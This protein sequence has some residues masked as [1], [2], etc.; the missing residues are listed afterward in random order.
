[1]QVR[2]ISV[3]LLIDLSESTNDPL[4]NSKSGVDFSTGDNEDGES[5]E[6]TI[7]D[8]SREAAVLMSEAMN[9]V[10]DP[11]AI[12]GFDSN[13]RHDVE[14]YRFKD[15]DDSYNDDVKSHLAG[16]TGQ[17]S[18]RMGAAIRHSGSILNQYTSSKKILFVLTDGEPADNDVRDPQ[19]LRFDT[20]KA[21]E[22]LATKGVKT[23]CL[24]LDP[25][26]DEYVSRIFG[27]KNYLILDHVSRLPEKLPELY[28]SLTK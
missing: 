1:L 2:D 17:L 21:V 4:P 7:L 16:M 9:K 18:T 22:E 11:F 14:Y 24:T 15:F 26:A 23:F 20:K 8:L 12:H 13:G 27:A 6:P 19:H 5:K 3:I 25:H 28:L 10:G